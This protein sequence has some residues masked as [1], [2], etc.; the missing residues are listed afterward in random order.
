MKPTIQNIKDL[1]STID[2]KKKF[3]IRESEHL[4]ERI[5]HLNVEV[6][7]LQDDFQEKSMQFQDFT[8]KQGQFQSS[9]KYLQDHASEY[10]KGI[11][12]NLKDEIKE[13][14]PKIVESFK[15]AFKKTI[16]KQKQRRKYKIES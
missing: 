11:A 2:Q 13:D 12:T 10:T 15:R 6:E 4:N 3:Y 1:R 5:T 7:L 9:I 14:G 8:D 16:H